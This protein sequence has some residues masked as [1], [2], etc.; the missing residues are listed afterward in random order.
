MPSPH[1]DAVLLDKANPEAHVKVQEEPWS[2]VAVHVGVIPFVG[3][4]MAGQIMAVD[5]K[6]ILTF[7]GIMTTGRCTKYRKVKFRMYF[8]PTYI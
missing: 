4:A 1:T 5:K 2:V 8:L 6:S 3:V 7:V